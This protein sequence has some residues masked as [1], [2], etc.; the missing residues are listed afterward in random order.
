MG[1][2]AFGIMI[3]FIGTTLGSACV[4]FMK[5]SLSERVTKVLSGFAAGVMVA[6]SVWSLLIPAIEMSA[7]NG[8]GKM[9]FIPAV[10]GFLRGSGGTEGLSCQIYDVN[11]C[12][13][14]A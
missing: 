3:P 10:T 4:F 8:M 7:D 2:I 13:N 6:A 9:A 12:S 11:S 1:T 5:G 14:T